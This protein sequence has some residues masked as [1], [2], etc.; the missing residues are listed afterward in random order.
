MGQRLLP[1]RLFL[2]LIDIA[3]LF[4]LH[5]GEHNFYAREHDTFA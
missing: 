1:T 2:F 5:Y 3:N 4:F